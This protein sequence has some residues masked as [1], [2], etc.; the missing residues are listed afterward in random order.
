MFMAERY[1]AFRTSLST[2]YTNFLA[3]Y[4][5]ILGIRLTD[6]HMAGLAAIR[7]FWTEPFFTNGTG[8]DMSGTGL[9]I[10]RFTDLDT[11]D[12]SQLPTKTTRYQVGIT[13]FLFTMG[14]RRFT[15][16]ANL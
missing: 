3:T 14:A 8:I 6:A 12:T 9:A 1:L 5:A 7:I 4:I 16:R 15:T 13:N 10:T 2:T 11:I